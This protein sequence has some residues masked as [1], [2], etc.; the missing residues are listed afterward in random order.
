MKYS[1]PNLVKH[2]KDLHTKNDQTLIK[3][4]KDF[5]KWRDTL[6][7]WTERLN[8]VRK[9]I[10]SKFIYRCNTIPIKISTELFVLTY[11][12]Y[13]EG[14]SSWSNQKVLLKKNKV[15]GF[16][17]IPRIHVI[18]KVW[19][20][21]KVTQIKETEYRDRP[22]HTCSSGSTD[23]QRHPVGHI[24]IIQPSKAILGA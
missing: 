3:D 24:L 2:V 18:K 10:L 17:R 15:W 21:W 8:T 16:A 1:S 14:K 12:F 13:T 20:W 5:N 7:L 11:C 4:I 22:P 9:S 19:H 6:G 23:M